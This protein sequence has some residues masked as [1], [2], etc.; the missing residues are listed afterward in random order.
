MAK[1]GAFENTVARIIAKAFKS[2][3]IEEDDCYRTKNSGATK[4]QPGDIQFSPAFAKL[5][6]VL[7]ECKHYRNVRINSGK[8][9]DHQP[10]SYPIKAWWQQLLKEE[11]DY[12]KTH[13]KKFK[14][15]GLLIFRQNSCPIVVGM[16]LDTYELLLGHPFSWTPYKWSMIT[17]W[18]LRPVILVPLK[19]FLFLYVSSKKK[20]K[21]N[22][23]RN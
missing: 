12:A 3:G 22:V 20:G 11:K 13:K 23:V 16:H 17:S 15:P 5:F 4:R 6:P 1:G 9:L 21:K 8:S 18:K 19:E 2:L 10:K 14:K 7:I